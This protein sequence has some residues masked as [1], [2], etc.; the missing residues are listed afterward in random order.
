ME[1]KKTNG[2]IIREEKLNFQDPFGIKDVIL[3]GDIPSL[4]SELRYI[5]MSSNKNEPCSENSKP[6]G[7]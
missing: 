5:K 4:K 2:K 3:G 1:D 6:N 7:K